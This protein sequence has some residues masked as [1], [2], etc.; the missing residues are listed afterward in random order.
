[1]KVEEPA[2]EME[3]G[4]VETS[5]MPVESALTPAESFIRRQ[6]H[7]AT[8]K[9]QIAT[10][11]TAVISSP[12]DDVMIMFNIIGN[13]II[14]RGSTALEVCWGCSPQAFTPNRREESN[15]EAAG[16]FLS[17]V[18]ICSMQQGTKSK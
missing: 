10:L 12:E 7:V 15:N 5:P 11:C 3:T 16:L 9:E 14:M 8:A 2:E 4:S 17:I 6:V 13:R 1:M 18:L